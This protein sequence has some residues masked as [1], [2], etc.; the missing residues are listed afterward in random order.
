VRST[1]ETVGRQLS[2]APAICTMFG[3]YK[4]SM[5]VSDLEIVE[6][7]LIERSRHD[8]EVIRHCKI[9][10]SNISSIE[11]V[12]YTWAMGWNTAYRGE[13]N[14]TAEFLIL[15]LLVS[16][17]KTGWGHGLFLL[18][19]LLLGIVSIISIIGKQ[20]FL[21]IRAGN[22][23]ITLEIYKTDSLLVEAF[24]E[25]LSKKIGSNPMQN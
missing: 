13:F 7:Y 3:P 25:L 21:V 8:G 6:P 2:G 16:Q 1:E 19:F 9:L 12:R 17:S 18:S 20:K 14:G 23:S 22:A 10:L 4:L 24:V 15:C 5:G 11:I